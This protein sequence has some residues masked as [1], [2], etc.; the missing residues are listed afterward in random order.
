MSGALD[1]CLTVVVESRPLRAVNDFVLDVQ[2]QRVAGAVD[3]SEQALRVS[4]HGRAGD[5]GAIDVV[6]R[7]GGA[8]TVDV[9]ESWEL[10]AVG[11]GGDVEAPRA[12]ARGATIAEVGDGECLCG[13]T[14]LERR[15]SRQSC[16]DS[17]SEDGGVDHFGLLGVIFEV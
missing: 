15:G 11:R 16:G 5:G 9:G 6:G 4:R 7:V 2:L 17:G 8:G 12:A 10:V 3:P 1:A 14:R 13:L